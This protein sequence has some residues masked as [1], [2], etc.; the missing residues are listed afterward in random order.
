MLF[1]ESE[2]LVTIHDLEKW[3]VQM[4]R[5]GTRMMAWL[6]VAMLFFSQTSVFAENESGTITIGGAGSGKEVSF[7]VADLKAIPQEA[8]I[9]EDYT[10]NTKSGEKTAKV[11]GVSLAYILKE[12][13]M[14]TALE[15]EVLMSASDGYA[16]EPQLLS[17]LF[18]DT[19]KYVVAYE[20]DGQL[21]DDD[22]I[23]DQEDVRVYR[24]QKEAGEFGTVFKLVAS[25]S[26]GEAISVEDTADT[27]TELVT[28]F[29]DLEGQK[30]V[31]KTAVNEL[32]S[33]KV[34]DGMGDGLYHPELN[35][36]RAQFCKML[37]AG[38]EIE[39]A[40]YTGA[41]TDV[42]S[43][44]WHANYIQ[45]AVGIGLFNGYPD[46]SFLPEKM[47][48]RQEMAA[49]AA[50]AAV[51]EEKVSQEKLEKFVMSK[52]LFTDKESVPDWA[53]NGVAWLEAQGVFNDITE[54]SFLPTEMVNRGE[55][56]LVVY[57]V[58]FQ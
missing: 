8:Q 37:I 11:T 26:I 46:G 19:L 12:V 52:S 34:I 27:S 20:V 29:S 47:I 15:A 58:L 35:F 18:D 42:K 36:T 14:V 44:D 24:K 41:F 10:Y 50:R 13:A 32:V 25:I 39:L 33:R 57:R 55:A 1:F 7:S 38:M 45:T 28:V 23:A 6:L 54:N 9:H 17:D 4:K 22:G 5:N 31:I 21:L 3:R 43:A 49:V 51:Y 16:I 30:E 2:E 40:E 48:T 53:A 56:A